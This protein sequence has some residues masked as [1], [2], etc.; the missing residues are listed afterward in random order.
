VDGKRFDE[1]TRRLGDPTP[2]RRALRLLG[3]GI[4][5]ALAAAA[6]PGAAAP[7]NKCGRLTCAA[8]ETCLKGPGGPRC[9]PTALVCGKTCLAAPCQE[10]C[11]VCDPA[12]GACVP[13]ANG[14]ACE[15][16]NDLCTVGDSC[17]N[18]TC[19]AGDPVT[20]TGGRVCSGGQCI[21]DPATTCPTDQVLD[22]DTCGCTGSST[23]GGCPGGQ[24]LCGGK[25]VSNDCPHGHFNRTTCT[26][27]PAGTCV[28]TDTEGNDFCYGRS[29]SNG[30]VVD[31]ATC[32]CVCPA[33]TAACS[34]SGA[35][36]QG[37]CPDGA[38]CCYSGGAIVGCCASGTL[39]DASS[40]T[41]VC[42]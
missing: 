12:S 14:T 34:T 37:C 36:A 1:W 25:C 20:C 13:A 15:A 22:P 30:A 33:G 7:P 31:P 3:A 41:L 38:T 27:C 10:P 35:G 16:D 19:V 42:V 21:C 29:C 32:T 6:R 40:G 23:G 28:A 2:R 4:T 17:Q 24:V 9:C 39:C 26:C 5:S 11:Q 18:G 8:G